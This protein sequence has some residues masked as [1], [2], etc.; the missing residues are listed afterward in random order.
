MCRRLAPRHLT[1]KADGS[2]FTVQSSNA[3]SSG[4]SGITQRVNNNQGAAQSVTV[5]GTEIAIAGSA[6]LDEAI[7]AINAKSSITGVAAGKDQAGTKL[8]FTG[9]ADGNSFTI[10][11][12]EYNTLGVASTE[13]SVA[14]ISD[15]GQTSLISTL[16]FKGGDSFSVN[17]QTVNLTATD[18][19]G[20][21]VQKVG[22]ATNG[23]VTASYDATANK[24]SFTAADSRTAVQL[25]DG[26]T[27]TSKVSN[28]GFTATDFAA[29]AGQ[30]SSQSALAGKSITVQVGSGT[31]MNT[32]TITF[33]NAPGQ[34]STLAQ[35]NE[36]LAP[37]NA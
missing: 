32:A 21:L 27:A 15:P 13:A 14:G 25:G 20:S 5:N 11:G 29:G 26:S 10:K 22:A 16:G 31:S 17:G 19:I 6:T 1:G 35:L 28:L 4:F 2:A 7:A 9:G 33:G 8:T 23:A 18:T 3:A 24:F 30:P 12:S 36:A 34:V 37:A